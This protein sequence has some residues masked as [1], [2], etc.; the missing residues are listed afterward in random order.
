MATKPILFTAWSVRAIL[1][2]HKTQTRRVAKPQPT[3]QDNGFWE[4]RRD[5]HFFD[6]RDGKAVS[7]IRTNALDYLGDALV[8]I[9]PYQVGDVLW[10]RENLIMCGEVDTGAAWLAYAADNRD[11]C[12]TREQDQW[13]KDYD[14][15]VQNGG[16]TYFKTIPSIHMPKWACRL[17]LRV[18][19]VR[20]Q[21][22]QDISH[23]DALAE[24]CLGT[25]WVE[26]TPRIAGPHTD[27]GVLPVEEYESVWDRL[28]AKRGH[29]WSQNHWAWAYTFEQTEKPEDF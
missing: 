17:F 14:A 27:A 13:A 10:V 29:P 23:E 18:T 20:A 5:K 4:L 3:L 11:V 9:A 28:N 26:G 7:V 15:P 1:A 24:G 19:E 12:C 6:P 22:V 8:G 16:L 21:R 25:D 2:G